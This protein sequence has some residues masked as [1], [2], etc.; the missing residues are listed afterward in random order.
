MITAR[1]NS[2]CRRCVIDCRF[3]KDDE[4]FVSITAKVLINDL[5]FDKQLYD[6]SNFNGRVAQ[7]D[8]APDY[9]SGDCRFESCRGQPIFFISRQNRLLRWYPGEDVMLTSTET[10]FYFILHEQ[11]QLNQALSSTQFLNQKK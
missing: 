10:T 1:M 11:T 7:L 9:G 3:T 2:S 6:D 5:Q 8:K 4:L